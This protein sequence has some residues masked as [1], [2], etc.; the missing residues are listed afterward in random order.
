[1]RFEPA[2]GLRFSTYAYHRIRGAMLDWLRRNDTVSRQ[3]RARM[4]ELA[5]RTVHISLKLEAILL[6]E[7]AGNFV[8]D[9]EDRDGIQ[10]LL[11]RLHGKQREVIRLAWLHGWNGR[12]IGRALGV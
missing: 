6:D 9:C 5:P 4:A 8:Q 11:R 2:R 1:E 10:D 3:M 7:A 12:Q